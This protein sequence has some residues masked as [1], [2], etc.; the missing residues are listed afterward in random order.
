MRDNIAYIIKKVKI[1]LVDEWGKWV[2]AGGKWVYKITNMNFLA[3]LL[4]TILSCLQAGIAP[5]ATQ[6]RPR[7]EVLV[8]SQIDLLAAQFEQLYAQWRAGTLRA[9]RETPDPAPPAPAVVGSEPKHSFA[10]PG[11]AE[12]PKAAPQAG[13]TPPQPT[14]RPAN[15]RQTR[16]ITRHSLR[17]PPDPMACYPPWPNAAVSPT[18]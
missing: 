6:R 15:H 7:T 13:I 1:S 9:C 5:R 12:F 16:I 18:S 3:T 2:Y 14:P 4:H 8:W 11:V 10:R 17:E